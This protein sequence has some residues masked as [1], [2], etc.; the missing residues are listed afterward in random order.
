LFFYNFL[1]YFVYAVCRIYFRIEFHGADRVPRDGAVILAPNHASYADPILVSIPLR[2]RL[3]YMAWDK[4][5]R[6]PVLGALMRAFG[7]FPVNITAGDRGALRRSLEHLRSGGALMIFPEG[8]RTRDGRPMA[9]KPGIVRLAI[10]TGA[11]IVPVTIVGAYSAYSPHHTWPR[12]RKLKLY[13]HD[14][15]SL[16][17]PPRNGDK[18]LLRAY[19]FEQA[20]RLQAIVFGRL[21]SDEASC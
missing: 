4:M 18:E 16:T 21:A 2:R 9:F 1:R 8:S 5:F 14:P 3:R 6:V 19:E 13:Y 17:P 20:A 11:P 15:V 10:E 12:P 7:A